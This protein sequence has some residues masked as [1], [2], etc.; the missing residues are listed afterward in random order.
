MSSRWW[1]PTRGTIAPDAVVL[2]LLTPDGDPAG[3]LGASLLGL[4]RA[5]A[6]SCESVAKGAVPSEFDLVKALTSTNE[7][8]R[9]HL[10][11]SVSKSLEPNYAGLLIRDVIDDADAA[12]LSLFRSCVAKGV[13]PPLAASRVGAVYGV[14]SRELG[15]YAILATNPKANPIALTDAADRALLS[16]VS[17][18]VSSEVGETKELVSKAPTTFVE[19][20]VRRDS[21]GRFTFET[22]SPPVKTPP[23]KGPMIAGEEESRPRRLSPFEQL[24]ARLGLD[25]TT[26]P[27]IVVEPDLPQI[28]ARPQRRVR[29]NKRANKRVKRSA[30]Q[31]QSTSGQLVSTSRNLTA[32]HR[33]LTTADRKLTVAQIQL[34]AQAMVAIREQ[35]GEKTREVVDPQRMRAFTEGQSDFMTMPSP[36]AAAFPEMYASL[37]WHIPSKTGEEFRR[38]Q[39]MVGTAQQDSPRRF[40]LGHLLRLMGQPAEHG[41]EGVP[42]ARKYQEERDNRAGAAEVAKNNM[43]KGYVVPITDH[44]HWL[45]YDDAENDYDAIRHQKAAMAAEVGF[46]SEDVGREM[47]EMSSIQD[48]YNGVDTIVYLQPMI[49]PKTGESENNYSRP[50]PI[51]DEYV[52]SSSDAIR[53][54]DER[55]S[56]NDINTDWSL[57]PNQAFRI[58]ENFL[59]F[60]DPKNEVVVHRWIIEPISE[61]QVAEYEKTDKHDRNISKALTMATEV[62]FRESDH[63]RSQVGRFIPKGRSLVAPTAIQ[64]SP[65]E[66]MRTKLG[67]SELKIEEVPKKEAS[68]LTQQR[69]VRAPGRRDRSKQSRRRVRPKAAPQNFTAASVKL[70]G[71]DRVLSVKMRKLLHSVGLAQAEEAL[72]YKIPKDNT[73]DIPDIPVLSDTSQFKVLA[74][75]DWNSFLDTLTEDDQITLGTDGGIVPIFNYSKNELLKIG[76]R[77]GLLNFDHAQAQLVNHVANRMRDTIHDFDE[78]PLGRPIPIGDSLDEEKA[79]WHYIS[80]AFDEH[81]EVEQITVY[82]DDPAGSGHRI[83]LMS[84][85]VPISKQYLVEFDPDEVNLLDG[86]QPLEIVNIGEYRT[87]SVHVN[88]AGEMVPL[89]PI[90]TDLAGVGALNVP[91]QIFR[92]VSAR[93]N[94][95][96]VQ[97][98]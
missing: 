34:Q 6:A 30:G 38:N 13:S 79:L 4:H 1:A 31:L 16:Y 96:R 97:P 37:V 85:T 87:K 91:V 51:V 42:D 70:Q 46:K 63:P 41:I 10:S 72:V 61:Y 2:A 54:A 27:E 29:S 82:W 18:L 83:Q 59:P 11:A 76:E 98:E 49:D 36:G 69:T 62:E 32:K 95:H 94:R 78:R 56:E 58:N 66:Q 9:D 23:V 5:G 21:I 81:P 24:R 64:P 67:L 90:D 60:W 35:Q 26:A 45:E 53:G 7:Q 3:D 86:S 71:S 55:G 17:K 73:A 68:I 92:V 20:D 14:P 40:R 47:S 43:P 8:L 65:F 33:R 12:V 80:D 19:S 93:V 57:D 84:S 25:R 22:D 39:K 15:K 89:L 28:S 50:V 52:I 77:K 88:K 48:Y 75:S 44:M 74:G